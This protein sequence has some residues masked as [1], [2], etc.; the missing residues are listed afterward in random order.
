[1]PELDPIVPDEAVVIPV[2]F[3][4]DPGDPP[5]GSASG[6]PEGGTL[7][8]DNIPRE[9]WPLTEVCACPKKGAG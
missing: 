9:R 5:L 2:P 6:G 7:P 3:A 8:G 1:M 4:P